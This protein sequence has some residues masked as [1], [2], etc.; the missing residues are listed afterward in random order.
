MFSKSNDTQYIGKIRYLDFKIKD[1][2]INTPISNIQAALIKRI[3]FEHEKELRVII[4]NP[5]TFDKFEFKE[6]EKEKGM[7]AA[8]DECY[9]FIPSQKGI[10]I[11]VDLNILIE[12]LYISPTSQ[13][14]FVNLVR[15][16]LR[17]IC[18]IKGYN[19]FPV[20]KSDLYDQPQY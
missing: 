19:E 13:D 1:L 15:E 5:L 14:W 2:K 9:K 11:E 12:K 10:E 18:K 17:E 16:F 7:E 3:S 8:F 4:D 6:I 20:I